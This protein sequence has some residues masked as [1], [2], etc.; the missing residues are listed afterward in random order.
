MR[1]GHKVHA[2]GAQTLRANGA[3][4]LRA[5]GAQMPE[6]IYI[7]AKLHLHGAQ[8]PTPRVRA[9]LLAGAMYKY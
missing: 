8:T 1:T 4:T 7:F 3:Q 9:H 6:L 2:H 5:N